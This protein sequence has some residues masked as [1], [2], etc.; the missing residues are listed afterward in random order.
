ML[1]EIYINN[2]KNMK[3]LVFLFYYLSQT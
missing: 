1:N 2:V 3:N